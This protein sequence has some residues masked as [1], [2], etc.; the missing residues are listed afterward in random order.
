VQVRVLGNVVVVEALGLALGHHA[1]E[2]AH[3]GVVEEAHVLAFE[4]LD[5]HVVEPDQPLQ[6]LAVGAE[7][8]GAGLLLCLQFLVAP[9]AAVQLL[10]VAVQVLHRLRV[11]QLL[12][13]VVDHAGYR[14]YARVHPVR[15]GVFQ[16]EPLLLFVL[17]FLDE[18]VVQEFGPVHALVRVFV[19]Q[20]D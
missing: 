15:E 14:E 13:F 17:G 3:R 12:H 9:H 20:S 8:R 7:L 16:N 5:G 18:G 4:F 10:L 2:H 6:E 1:A 11:D 19:Q